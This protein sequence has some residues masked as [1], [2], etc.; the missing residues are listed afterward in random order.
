MMII[1]ATKTENFNGRY[2]E[3]NYLPKVPSF[4][5]TK[6]NIMVSGLTPKFPIKNTIKKAK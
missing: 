2:V 4:S 5:N 6:T 3:V 1:P